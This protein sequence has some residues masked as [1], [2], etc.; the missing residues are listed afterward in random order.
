MRKFKIRFKEKAWDGSKED[1]QE[2]KRSGDPDLASW[3]T[4]DGWSDTIE[5]NSVMEALQKAEAKCTEYE[6]KA[7]KHGNIIQV[8][9]EVE[10]SIGPWM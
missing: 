8:S 6:E 2:Y 10:L 4:V 7:A 5:A 1:Y 9:C 3:T